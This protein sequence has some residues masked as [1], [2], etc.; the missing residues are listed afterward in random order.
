M[1]KCITVIHASK[2]IRFVVND[3]NRDFEIFKHELQNKFECNE[4]ISLYINHPEYEPIEISS[5]DE[6]I[7]GDELY[8]TSE[9]EDNTT[10]D[11]ED[12]TKLCNM[13]LYENLCVEL[14]KH[15]KKAPTSAVYSMEAAEKLKQYQQKYK[16]LTDKKDAV[17][18]DIGIKYDISAR[19][20]KEMNTVKYY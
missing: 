19:I 7:T 12:N 20:A 11:D 4:I 10:S 17:E 5:T 1:M 8:I 14:L 13:R 16:D 6:L 3:T 2:A 18:L 9:D 15:G